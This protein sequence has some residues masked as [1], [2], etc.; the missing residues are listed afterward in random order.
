MCRS[1]KHLL[2]AFASPPTSTTTASFRPTRTTVASPCPT[3]QETITQ[4]GTGHCFKVNEGFT[5]SSTSAAR[6]ME[7]D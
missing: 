4:F 6:T 7:T 5:Q 2:I 3:S 1:L